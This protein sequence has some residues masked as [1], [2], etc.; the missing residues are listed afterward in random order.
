[1]GMLPRPLPGAPILMPSRRISFRQLAVITLVS[2]LTAIGLAEWILASRGQG[3]VVIPFYNKLHPYVM[4]QP[5]GGLRFVSTDLSSPGHVMSRH[6][7]PVH[8]YT[9][10][11]GFRVPSPDYDLPKRKPPGQLRV[12]VLGGSAVQ[13]GS[14]YELTIT[15][16]LK[17]LLHERFPSRDIEVINA[18]IVSSVSRQ[19][20]AY[21]LFTVAEYEPDVVILYDGFNDLM[22]PLNYESRS[23]FPYNFQTMQ[24][25]WNAYRDS[26][27]APLWRIALDRSRLFRAW[28]A[29]RKQPSDGTPAGVAPAGLFVGPNA[30][31]AQ[32]ILADPDW[33]RAHVLAY[34]SNWKKLIQ[35]SNVYGYRPVC[36]LQPTAAFDPIHG[37]DVT[38]E[39]YQLEEPAARAWLAAIQMLY[40]ETSRQIEDLRSAYPE[41]PFLDLGQALVPAKEHF[42]DIVHLYDE[43]NQ[44]PARLIAAEIW[45]TD[46]SP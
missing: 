13:T 4:F 29:W 28:Q 16:F 3:K 8:H 44:A 19:S 42:W 18:G 7:R 10:S 41:V 22:L 21:L 6:T 46:A 20:I 17:T 24:A 1:M 33:V 30:K 43:S 14:N 26:Y 40:Q 39:G 27:R 37:L 15:G 9:H 32:Q 31:T 36:V 45:P 34:L 38:T 5:H 25:A 11:D 35:L 2:T 23:N 12:V